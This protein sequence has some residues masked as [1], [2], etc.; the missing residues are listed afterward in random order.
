MSNRKKK[1]NNSINKCP[2]FIWVALTV[3]CALIMG[4]VM[5][6]V[7]DYTWK[8]TWDHPVFAA[9]LLDERDPAPKPEEEE[10]VAVIEEAIPSP[11]VP[12]PTPTEE[13]AAEVTEEEP[14]EEQEPEEEKLV[15]DEEYMELYGEIPFYIDD[16]GAVKYVTWNDN[17][18]RSKYYENP[19][20]R[21]ITSEYP[22]QH[23]EPDYYADALFIGDSRIGGL[24]VYSG[25]SEATFCYKNGLSI[26]NMMESTVNAGYGLNTTV[27][28]VLAARQYNKI[29]VMF[30]INEIGTGYTSDFAEKFGENLAI[31]RTYQPDAK[32]IIL[33]NTYVTKEK[34]LSSPIYNNDNINAKNAAIAAYANGEDIFYFDMNPALVDDEGYMREEISRDGI[35]ITAQYYYLWVDWM[36]EHGL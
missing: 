19:G 35:H 27:P 15:S 13:P 14:E 33:A 17:E 26:Y 28:E 24:G 3:I 10:R 20:V 31:I 30:G 11:V 22:Y 29:Y 1:R 5:T 36:N 2:L 7:E 16:G 18:P 4:V 12:T 9:V 25:W 8:L 32:I 6:Q 23:V 21:P 34:D